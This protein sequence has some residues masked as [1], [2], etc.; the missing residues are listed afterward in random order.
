MLDNNC[1][2]KFY[3]NQYDLEQIYENDAEDVK[4]KQDVDEKPD[5]QKI[6]PDKP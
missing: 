1:G 3:Q 2:T 6:R 5:I 4:D